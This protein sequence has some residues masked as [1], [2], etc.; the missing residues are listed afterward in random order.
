MQVNRV[1]F[2]YDIIIRIHRD[3]CKKCKFS[4]WLISFQP[5]FRINVEKVFP[6]YNWYIFHIAKLRHKCYTPFSFILC[7]A[8]RE[9]MNR[10]SCWIW[11]S[12]NIHYCVKLQWM[13]INVVYKSKMSTIPNARIVLYSNNVTWQS[14]INF[15]IF[16]KPIHKRRQLL[17][18]A[19]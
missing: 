14:K 4:H 13:S 6:F 2:L 15:P 18:F 8:E 17:H 7:A 10:V 19:F 9:K 5:A 12:N 11:N 3:T 1:L 16:C